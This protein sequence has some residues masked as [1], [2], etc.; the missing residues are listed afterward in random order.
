[1]RV[2]VRI[3][4]WGLACA[5]FAVTHE[6]AAADVRV[7]IRN[8]S[9]SGS[10]AL[11]PFT[12]AAHDGTFDAFDA[13]SM[14]GMGIENVAELGDGTALVSEITSA[15]PAAVTATAIATD[16]GFGSGIFLPGSSGSVVLSLDPSIHRYLTYGAMVVPSNDAFLGNDSPTSVELFDDG[17]DFVAP[18]FTLTGN[19][20][21]D[22]GT[23]LN[24]LLGAAYI[25]GQDATIG[26]DENGVLH[27]TDLTTEF[28]PYDGS[29]VPSGSMFTV[30]PMNETQIAS[31][32][33]QIVPEP[34]SLV[35]AGL[36][37]AAMFSIGLHRRN[38]GRS[39]AGR[40]GHCS[41]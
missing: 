4:F 33:F 36:G 38:R 14:A 16:G 19:R 10:V 30:T 22:A 8:L 29:V 37:I 23:E 2:T 26:A 5:S 25:V 11:S 31:F 6:A 1:M 7:T 9:P 40:N 24:Q 27:L 34:S 39:L 13:G 32:S 15:Q 12:L 41:G 35:L 21:W 17:G 18:D 3:I 28:S 20:I